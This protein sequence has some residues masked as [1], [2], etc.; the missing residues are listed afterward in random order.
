M[1]Q[2]ANGN[3]ALAYT[4]VSES[5]YPSLR[6]TG[7]FASDEPG[8]MT[9]EEGII[10]TGTQSDPSFRYGDYSQMTIDPVDDLTFWSIG[11]YFTGGAR[12]NHVGVFKIAP[13]L[14]NDVGIVS[15]DSP[16]NG[17]LSDSEPV[18]VTIRNYGIADQTDIPVSYQIDG[19]PMVNEVFLG[20]VPANTNQQYTFEATGDFSIVGHTYEIHAT[21]NLTND[22]NEENDTVT[23]YVKHLYTDDVGVTEVVTPVSGAELTTSETITVI[24]KNYGAETQT[25]FDVLFSLNGDTPVTEQIS[26]PLGSEE[27]MTYIFEETGDFSDVMDHELFVTTSLPGDGEPANDSVTAIITN[28]LC[29]P[30]LDCSQ[31]VGI[32]A[33][34]LGFIDNESGCDPNGYGNYSN[35]STNLGQGTSN[36]LTITTGYGS[37]FVKTWIDFNDNFVFESDEVVVNDYEIADGQSAGTYTETMPLDIPDDANLGEHLMRVKT[38]Y[39]QSVPEDPCEETMFGETEDYK[40]MIDY[41]TGIGIQSLEPNDLIVYNAGN[42]YFVVSFTPVHLTETMIVTLHNLQ[43]HTLIHNRVENVNG[44]YEY[45]FDMS[46]APKGIYLLRLGSDTFGKVKRIVVQ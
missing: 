28:T 21:T 33:L 20:T 45:D 27:T 34:Q 3:I 22:Q 39:N 1:C 42:N 32:Y 10:A 23:A 14:A 5:Q 8:I 41:T 36:D 31:G 40:A 46:Y 6:Y 7:R 35:L 15:I 2:D 44:K 30:Q 12:K 18:S 43:G 29:Q 11:E 13:D 24:V 16:V 26:G 19:G 4:I 25:D 17:I 38:N 37:V 9:L